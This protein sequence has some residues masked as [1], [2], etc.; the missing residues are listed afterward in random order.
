MQTIKFRYLSQEDILSLNI[1]YEDVIEVVK[2]VM[3]AHGK[4]LCQVPIKIHVNTRDASFLMQCL[5]TFMATL[6]LLA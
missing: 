3:S 4:G 1:P 5:P 2:R 6:K